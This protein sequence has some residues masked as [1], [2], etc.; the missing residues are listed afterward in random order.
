MS[1][2]LQLSQNNLLNLT[3]FICGRYLSVSPIYINGG[4]SICG[5]CPPSGYRNFVYEELAKFMTFPCTYNN[6]TSLLSWDQV[7][8]HESFCPFKPSSLMCPKHNCG[9]VLFA[10]NI[11]HHVMTSHQELIM[12]NNFTSTR[13]LQNINF[14]EFSNGL[15][16]HIVNVRN[17]PYLMMIYERGL[18]DTDSDQICSYDFSFGVFS[19]YQNVDSCTK[20]DLDVSVEDGLGNKVSFYWRKEVLE[21]YNYNIHCLHCLGDLCVYELRNH[22]TNI[23]NTGDITMQYTIKLY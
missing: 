9:L 3:C 19:Y 23:K 17:Q 13:R 16:V 18:R 20:Y 22:L 6:C 8:H 4:Q 5:R 12:Q 1:F 7:K 11:L 10:R 15:K 2:Q 14:C 21:E